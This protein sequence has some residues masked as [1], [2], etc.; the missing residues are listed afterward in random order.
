MKSEALLKVRMRLNSVSCT[1]KIGRMMARQQYRVN[2]RG[3]FF[4][5]AAA[6]AHMERETVPAAVT[7]R[8]LSQRENPM[9]R[10]L[11]FAAS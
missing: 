3:G 4:I 6:A 8:R 10:V 5:T 9:E 1:P 2:F 11:L 7:P